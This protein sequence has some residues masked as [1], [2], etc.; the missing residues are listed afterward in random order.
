M[1]PFTKERLYLSVVFVVVLM[2][3]SCVT[4]NLNLTN[5]GRYYTALKWYNDNLETYLQSYR[6]ASPATQAEWK[7][8]ID[9]VFKVGDSILKEWK[10]VLGSGSAGTQEDLWNKARAQILGML[11]TY[12][13]IQ[14][15]E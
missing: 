6:T 7:Q 2:L 8:K 10:N 3:G 5:E 11:V 9:P 14:V 13:I 15:K 1:K 4:T 12:N